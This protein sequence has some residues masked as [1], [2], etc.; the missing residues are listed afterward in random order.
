MELEDVSEQDERIR[1]QLMRKDKTAMLLK[2]NKVAIDKSLTSL[3]DFLSKSGGRRN[4]SPS[5]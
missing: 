4:M 2:N 5:H 3:D 1:Q